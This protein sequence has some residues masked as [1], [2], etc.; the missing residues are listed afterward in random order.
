MNVCD[1]IGEH[2]IGNVYVK[3]NYFIEIDVR[4]T[5]FYQICN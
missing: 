1:N 3:V 4:K 5:L 2:M